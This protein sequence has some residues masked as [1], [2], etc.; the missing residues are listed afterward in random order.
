MDLPAHSSRITPEQG[1]AVPLPSAGLTSSSRKDSSPQGS[2]GRW[3]PRE[4]TS[5]LISMSV[6][7]LTEVSTSVNIRV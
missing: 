6:D 7:T 5:S 2:K 3:I 1:V 4:H